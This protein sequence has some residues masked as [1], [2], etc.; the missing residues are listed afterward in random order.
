MVRISQLWPA[1]LQSVRLTLNVWAVIDVHGLAG[2]T[3]RSLE[4]RS[5]HTRLGTFGEW[6]CFKTLNSNKQHSSD[7]V[8]ACHK[9]QRARC[10]PRFTG[11]FELHQLLYASGTVSHYANET[12]VFIRRII[13]LCWCHKCISISCSTSST[14][15]LYYKLSGIINMW[16]ETLDL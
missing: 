15:R 4:L 14:Q 8:W 1:F 6:F 12:V 5:W 2:K 9:D 10:R 11:W 3:K 16:Q 7:M 13:W